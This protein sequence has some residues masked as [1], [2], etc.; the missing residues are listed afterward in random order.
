MLVSDVHYD[1]SVFVYRMTSVLPRPTKYD[2][3]RLSI[4]YQSFK[5][6][7]G[8]FRFLQKWPT[9]WTQVYQYTC[10]HT[11]I[12]IYTHTN[13]HAQ[14][15]P[16]PI[17]CTLKTPDQG[18]SYLDSVL[19]SYSLGLVHC[20]QSPCVRYFSLFFTVLWRYYC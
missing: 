5:N 20:Y 18:S 6:L 16:F 13:T 15:I 8:H 10:S 4:P 9:T 12:Q 19:C 17:G 7:G 1:D 2:K 11:E 3:I 14:N